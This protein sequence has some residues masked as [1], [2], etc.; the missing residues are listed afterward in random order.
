MAIQFHPHI[1]SLDILIKRWTKTNPQGI[2]CTTSV[3]GISPYIAEIGL[4]HKNS[5]LR[6]N[7]TCKRNFPTC[8]TLIQRKHLITKCA[9]I[10]IGGKAPIM[11]LM[12][13][14]IATSLAMQRLTSNTIAPTKRKKHLKFCE[15]FFLS[16]KKRLA[17]W[18]GVF[19]Y[20]C[21]ITKDCRFLPLRSLC[22]LLPLPQCRSLR[23]KYLHNRRWL[24]Q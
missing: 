20:V 4:S 23:L 17:D 16:I 24:L 15:V 12:T 13:L 18:Q 5:C 2:T 8:I 7:S 19:M 10:S 22:K 14:T 1:K 3:L 9:S 21:F 6:K 11:A